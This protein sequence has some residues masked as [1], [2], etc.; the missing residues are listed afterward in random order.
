MAP[1][2]ALYGKKCWSPIGWFKPN[3]AKLIG[4]NL[5]KDAIVNVKVIRERLQALQDQQKS[6]ANIRQQELNFKR[7]TKY[8]L[9]FCQWKYYW[10]LVK[11]EN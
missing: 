6:Y 2:E 11:K 5:V 7:G 4:P 3:E 8:Y 10:D 1:F 9:K